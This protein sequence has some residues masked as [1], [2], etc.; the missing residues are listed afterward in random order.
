MIM[1]MLFFWEVDL[2]F[3]RFLPSLI[4]DD[5][6][7]LPENRIRGS[8]GIFTFYIL[9]LTTYETHVQD[10]GPRQLSAPY[11]LNPYLQP[12]RVMQMQ[13]TWALGT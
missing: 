9:L 4:I 7:I 12:V 13:A 1:T 8:F 11:L 2:L 10:L 6:R 5:R 3:G